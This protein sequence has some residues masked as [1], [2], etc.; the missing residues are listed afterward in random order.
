MDQFFCFLDLDV[1]GGTWT[2]LCSFSKVE[3]E[4]LEVDKVEN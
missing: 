4:E 3:N 1:R 2:A